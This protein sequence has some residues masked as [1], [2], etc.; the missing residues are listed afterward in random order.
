ME[1]SITPEEGMSDRVDQKQGV[2]QLV[3][4]I[5]TA[6]SHHAIMVLLREQ[7]LPGGSHPGP[8]PTDR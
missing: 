4:E 6:V 3:E 1:N 5:S 8:Y 7:L 2:E